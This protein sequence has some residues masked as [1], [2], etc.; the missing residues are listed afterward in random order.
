M[1]FLKVHEERRKTAAHRDHP[2]W[3]ASITDDAWAQFS[4]LGLPTVKM[5]DWKYTDLTF[6]KRADYAAQTTHSVPAEANQYDHAASSEE[7]HSQLVFV[8]GLFSKERSSLGPLPTGAVLTNLAAGLSSHESVLKPR[9]EALLASRQSLTALN[10]SCFEDGLLLFLPPNSKIEKPIHMVYETSD[11][12][13]IDITHP[14]LFMFVGDNSDVTLIEDWAEGQT[15]ATTRN[16]VTDISLGTNAKLT[17]QVRNAPSATDIVLRHVNVEQQAHSSYDLSS[18]V[19]GSKLCRTDVNIHLRAPEATCA[20]RGIYLADS[21]QHIDHRTMVHHHAPYCTSLQDYR[22]VIS[23][24]GRAIF[25]G[26]ITVD[27]GAD[28][29]NANQSNRNLL[30]S[31]EG[32]VD[33]KPQLEIFADDVKCS[34]G[35][36]IGRLDQD[37]LFYLRSR[38]FDKLEAK[39]VLTRAFLL[40]LLEHS[41]ATKQTVLEEQID[42]ILTDSFSKQD[43][44]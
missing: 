42:A 41:H 5:E 37:A 24:S 17:H 11:D 25:N 27:E 34:H 31:P 3:L 4:E 12:I 22:G 18:A 1:D 28:Q 19:L 13:P 9:L 43:S 38:G 14:A 35:S 20:L 32:R 7:W 10:T 16:I 8:N 40:E 21:A 30:L 29:T 33:T 36:T 6:L 39:R 26:G 44:P 15:D 23:G 2:P